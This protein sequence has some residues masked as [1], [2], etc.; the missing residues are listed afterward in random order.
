MVI[1]VAVFIAQLASTK[2]MLHVEI[3]SAISLSRSIVGRC[4]MHLLDFFHMERLMQMPSVV[5]EMC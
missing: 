1:I 3:Q 2:F 4:L 5:Q